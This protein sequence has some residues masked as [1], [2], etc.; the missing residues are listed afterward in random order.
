MTEASVQDKAVDLLLKAVPPGSR[1]ILF[2]SRATGRA[3]ADSDWDFLVVEP[4]VEDRLREMARLAAILGEALIPADVVVMSQAEF[5]YWQTTP[6]TLPSA[7]REE[8][9]VYESVV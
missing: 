4:H 9:V 8:G 3:R 1:V 6:G 7:V 5:D 2:G